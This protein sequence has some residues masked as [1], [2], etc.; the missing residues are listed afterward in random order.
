MDYLIGYFCL[1]ACSTKSISFFLICQAGGR[2]PVS[3]VALS[4]CTTWVLIRE[5][6]TV[7]VR[8]SFPF[9]PFFIS[10]FHVIGWIMLDHAGSCWIWKSNGE[11][12]GSV[13]G[14]ASGQGTSMW[15]GT[16]SKWVFR[17]FHPSCY[18]SGFYFLQSPVR[19]L[20]VRSICATSYS[21]LGCMGC[22][23][24]FRVGYFDVASPRGCTP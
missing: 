2:G 6:Q 24:T 17:A 20:L 9:H 10:S 16:A 4:I 15:Y 21:E 13:S 8:L 14:E 1:V 3:R 18:L 5:I 22:D 12:E 7:E 11:R 19:L 23:V